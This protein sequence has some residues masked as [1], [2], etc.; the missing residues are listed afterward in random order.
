MYV[1]DT[2]NTL[3]RVPSASCSEGDTINV[4]GLDYTT[5]QNV[6]GHYIDGVNGTFTSDISL[7]CHEWRSFEYNPSFYILPAVLFVL[8]LFSCIYHWFLRL[9]G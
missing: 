5:I 6:N 4:N 1:V 8:C 9:R 7:V 2:E 3:Y